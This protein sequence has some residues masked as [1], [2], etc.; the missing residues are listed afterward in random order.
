MSIENIQKRRFLE[1]I[2]KIY[3]SLGTE[4]S[5]QEVSN[6]FGRYFS[7]FRPGSPIAVPF[8]DLNASSTID[9]EKINRIVVHTGFNVDVLYEAYF[10]ELDKMY[11][12]I[13]AFKFKIDDLKTRRAE[14]EKTVDDKLFAIGNTNGF[15]FAFTE[16]FNN[17]SNTD[18]QKSTAIV[19][20]SSRKVYLPKENSSLF[21]Y[22]GNVLNKTSTAQVDVYF[23]TQL[24][25]SQ[26]AVNITSIFD[27]LNNTEFKYIHKSPTIGVCTLKL[28]IPISIFSAETSG[29]S[30][31]EGKINSQKPLET[32]VLVIDPVDSARSL[33]FSK[34][35]ATDYD[36]F[37]FNFTTKRTNLVEIYFTKIEPDYSVSNTGNVEYIYD[38]RIEELIIAAPYY[39]SYATYVSKPISIPTDQNPNLSIDK[40][41]FDVQDQI[42]E[43]TSIKYYLA[44]DD[45]YS[46]NINQYNWVEVSPYTLRNSKENNVVNFNG[47]KL[48]QSN[49]VGVSG[50]SID[51][52]FESM[53]KI[54]RI[55]QYANPI[56]AYFNSSDETNRNFY[57]YRLAKF[58]KSAEPYE[59]YILES[60]NSNQIQQY[61]VSGTA[62]DRVT[63]QQV[64]SGTRK[65]IIYNSSFST[66]SSSQEFYQAQGVPYGSIY[67]KTSI[68]MSTPFSITRNFLKSL[69][70]Q[71]W[72]VSVY[73][74]G[75]ELSANGALAPGVL[76]SSLTWNFSQGQNNIV[77]II[78]KSTNDTNG[79]QTAFNG[80]VALMDGLSLLDIPNGVVYKNYLSCVKVEDLRNN[81]SNI[82]NVF[83]I[84]DWE[85]NKEIVYRRT[86]EIKEGSKIYYYVN[87][88]DSPELIR[89]RAD[90]FRGRDSYSSP[91]IV[92]YT[93]KFK[94]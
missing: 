9:I 34:N 32:S 6:L 87:N 75:N 63:W 20:T 50:T 11:E 85:N 29:I 61:Y 89:V 71:Y 10:D 12:L 84:I 93:L 79:A 65:D 73:L 53:T 52:T 58:P 49:L 74:N 88:S 86:E 38:F 22:V 90:L 47:T 1:T 28:S 14:L 64:L 70:A 91:S 72:D 48:V 81:H 76:S 13:S 24:K 80:Y 56:K 21:N 82:D 3:Y 27:G 42:P 54:P 45:G 31:I 23:D 51:S 59:P 19:D 5:L 4:P 8:N 94:H 62:L 68:F 78:N 55:T 40:V 83:S 36:N 35:S 92:S 46:R 7:R 67:L 44:V 69:S 30:V 15:Y 77:I 25:I 60:T 43:G 66:V 33:F 18:L 16:A 17:T 2:Y 37:S 26:N 39:S 41:M 57:L